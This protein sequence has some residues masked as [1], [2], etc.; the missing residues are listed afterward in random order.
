MRIGQRVRIARSVLQYGRRQ[1]R[2]AVF[3]QP[4]HQSFPGRVHGG[5]V[6]AMIDELGL[7]ALWSSEG[8]GKFGVTF[9]LDTSYRKPVPYNEQLL[10]RGVVVKSSPRFLVVES[11]IF[12]HTGELL[13][14]GTVKY[15]RLDIDKIA[16][17][18]DPHEEMCYN[19]NVFPED[20][21]LPQ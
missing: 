17:G 9:S 1:L 15:L 10:A 13:A 14:N 6:S 5:L 2:N 18:A 8:E 19:D 4:E 21:D 16:S 11:K 7:R 12:S 3:L 20:L